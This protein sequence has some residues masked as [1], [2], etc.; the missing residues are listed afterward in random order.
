MAHALARRRLSAG[1]EGSHWL[2]RHVRRNPLRRIF[3]SRAA[4]FA[5]HEHGERLGIFLEE[6]QR[7][8]EV[9]SLDGVAADADGRRLADASGRQLE[10]RLIRQRARTGDDADM[11]LAVDVARDDAELALVSRQDARAVRPDEMRLAA[12]HVAADLDHVLDRDV[13]ADADDD[14]EVRV[15]GLHDGVRCKARRHVDD[16]SRGSRRLHCLAHCV[17]HWH[18]A[19]NLTALAG[20][21]TADDLR[22]VVDHLLR[23][24]GRGLARDALHDDL[25]VFMN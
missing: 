19:G 9:R 23:V 1:D 2:V 25:C 21:H 12:F 10:R 6:L 5:D 3:L 4:D 7:V 24:E 17:E 22:A 8:D 13:L 20:R 14:I 18:S 16:R 15:D 11:A